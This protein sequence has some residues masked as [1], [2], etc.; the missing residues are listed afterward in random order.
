MQWVPTLIYFELFLQANMTQPLLINYLYLI[1]NLI[2]IHF[3]SPAV[4]D[5]HIPCPHIPYHLPQPI[6]ASEPHEQDYTLPGR[7]YLCHLRPYTCKYLNLT[8]NF[9]H[10]V[11]PSSSPILLPHICVLW[12]TAWSGCLAFNWCGENQVDVCHIS[13]KMG[14]QEPANIF[15]LKNKLLN[16]LIRVSLTFPLST[17]M[18]DFY[19]G[20]FKMYVV[21]MRNYTDISRTHS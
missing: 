18:N 14:K 21:L 11:P 7:C 1:H 19:M 13:D 16:Y 8:L 12:L 9:F 2:F 15:I 10:I 3:Q 20:T 17:L 6:K 5:E 4:A